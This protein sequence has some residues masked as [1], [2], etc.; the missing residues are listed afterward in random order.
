MLNQPLSDDNKFTINL[1]IFKDGQLHELKSVDIFIKGNNPKQAYNQ[2][3]N[4]Q[5][6]AYKELYPNSNFAV[7]IL[8]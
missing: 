2:I 7:V 4:A 5:I 6:A 1:Q 8:P 3:K